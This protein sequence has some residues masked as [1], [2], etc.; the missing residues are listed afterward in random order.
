MICELQRKRENARVAYKENL[1]KLQELQRKVNNSIQLQEEI[2]P[3]LEVQYRN[4]L[5]RVEK[6]WDIYMEMTRTLEKRGF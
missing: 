1:V 2:S 6:Y 4:V 5:K 3:K